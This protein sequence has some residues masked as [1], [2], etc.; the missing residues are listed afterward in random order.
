MR[1]SL[2][3]KTKLYLQLSKVSENICDCR[4]VRKLNAAVLKV[5]SVMNPNIFQGIYDNSN[6]TGK[7]RFYKWVIYKKKS[8]QSKHIMK[9][10]LEQYC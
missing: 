2:I 3:R 6:V 1:N 8:Y 4:I 7:T 10:A 5:L 9:N